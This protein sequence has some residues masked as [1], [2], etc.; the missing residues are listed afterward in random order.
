MV[1]LRLQLCFCLS[2]LCPQEPEVR[3]NSSTARVRM[4]VATG[5][6]QRSTSV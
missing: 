6:G 4:H 5:E 1:L 3:Q 2:G